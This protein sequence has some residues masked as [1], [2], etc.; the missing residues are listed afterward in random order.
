M[1]NNK[2]SAVIAHLVWLSL[3]GL[4]L[5]YITTSL[6][7]V[8]DITQFMPSNYKN[9]GNKV[10]L[11]LD[12]LQKGNTA[13]LL[14]LRMKGLQDK[15]LAKLSR[16]LKSKLDKNKSFINVHNGQQTISAQQ[17]ISGKYKTLYDY[18][19][20]LAPNTS[21]SKNELTG[22]LNQRLSELRSGLSIFKYTLS[23]DPQNHFIQYLWK[24][25]ERG[26]TTTHKG[27][28]FDKN[29]TSSLLL[30][31]L[32]LTDFNLDKQEAALQDIYQTIS[33]LSDNKNLQ[34]DITGT[35]V[36]A[37][38]TRAA[39]QSTSKTL[40]TIALILMAILF[41]WSYRS[42]RLFFI[43][44]LPLASAV[45]AALTM[46]N[47]IFQQVHGIIIA[48]GITLLGVCLDYPVHLFSH[49]NKKQTAQQT[50]R[51]IWPTLRLGVIST[52]LAYLAMLG[53]G[54]A[55]LSQLSI[56]AISGLI[57]SLLVTRWIVPFWLQLMSGDLN[58][59]HQYLSY[60]TQLKFHSN[61]KY[62]FGLSVVFFCLVI[63]GTNHNSIWSKNISDLSPIPNAAK[64]LD[65]E[66]RQSVGAPDVNHVFILSDKNSELLLQRT[67]KLKN[68][69]GSLQK[70]NLVSHIFSI[71]DFVPS[72]KTQLK[73]QQQLPKADTLKRNLDDAVSDLPF[74]QKFFTPFL[75][76]IEQSKILIPLDVDKV[77]ATPLGKNLQQDLFF[78]NEE[79]HSIVRLAGVKD[80][81]ALFSWLESKPSIQPYYLNLR[82]ATSALMADY[83]ETAL[84][85][86]LLGALIIT[87]IL[88]F[89]RPVKRVGHIILPVI[90]AVLLSLSIQIML[91]TPITLF[92]I[93]ALLL[94]IGIGL[95]YSLF[96]DRTWTSSEDYQHRLHGIFVSAASTLI[97]FGILGFSDIPVLSA[98]GQTV[99]FGVLG[100]FV[101]TLVFNINNNEKPENT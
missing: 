89:V 26:G 48:F 91:G 81:Q 52:S 66:L 35:P 63:I 39:I 65:R 92:H 94:I 57:V 58:I 9:D 70:N 56:F 49:R 22:S 59:R 88:F 25:T 50:L 96:F 27:V 10:Q 75:N 4:A 87:L 21:L 32:N 47:I 53:S 86:L 71:T 64:K 41:W 73:N 44:T 100:C 6:R 31:E 29:K 85:R 61:K 40:S 77:L 69:L 19:Y 68:E 51:S 33:E 55:G 34:I 17:F 82:Q 62:F 1:S 13:R 12:E 42:L 83:Q 30:I 37:V 46:T 14:I 78:K 43:A 28:W 16:Q 20:L 24:L 23:S 2:K 45:I 90:L 7:V 67:E 74:K 95:D 60:L 15:E 38:K 11:L 80:E 79:W 93:L 36:M 76:D 5:F 99:T 54:F 72:Q 97:T 8:S 18:R 98:L 101:L 3:L 84:F